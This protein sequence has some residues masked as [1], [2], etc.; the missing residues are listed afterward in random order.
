MNP[1]NLSPPLIMG[2][3]NTTPDSFKEPLYWILEGNHSGQDQI[4]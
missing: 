2:I 3:V 1:N 4:R